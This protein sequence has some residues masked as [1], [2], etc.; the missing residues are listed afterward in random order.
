[1]NILY[2]VG[3]VLAIG[4]TVLQAV[5]IER[6][7]RDVIRLKRLSGTAEQETEQRS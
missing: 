4:L 2:G 1:M 3:L 5:R 6:L 7:E